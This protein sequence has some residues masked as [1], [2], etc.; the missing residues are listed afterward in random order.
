M[1]LMQTT[2]VNYT[3]YPPTFE[4]RATHRLSH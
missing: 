2:Y 1:Q 4:L 3:K